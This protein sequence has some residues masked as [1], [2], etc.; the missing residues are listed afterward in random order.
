MQGALA[1]S[2]SAVA[3]DSYVFSF[4]AFTLLVV[5]FLL[6]FFLYLILRR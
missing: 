1:A 2:G 3:C 6:V 5:G 4:Y